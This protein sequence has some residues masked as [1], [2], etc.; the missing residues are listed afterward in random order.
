[1]SGIAE[2]LLN[3]GY[4]VT[5]SDL[6]KTEVTDHL[7]KLGA[8]IFI[9]HKSGNIGK[10]NVV[11]T[12]TAVGRSNPEVV[13]AE[14]NKI[15]VIPRIEMLA[16]LARLKYAVTIAGTHGKTTTT[17]MAALVLEK[18]NLDPTVVIGGR[19]KNI[20][21][22]AKL[23]HGEFLVAE[24]DES[25]G[26]F[27]KLSPAIAVVTNIDN[28]HLDYY[29]TLENI[30]TAFVKHINSVPFYG[31]AVLCLD[32]KNVLEILP[33]IKRRYQT[34]SLDGR[35]DF[36]ARNIKAL[37]SGSSFNVLYKNK[38]L[39]NITLHV[40]GMHN[41]LNSLAAIAVGVELSIPFPKIRKAISDFAGVGR[42]LEIKGNKKG[43]MIIDDY[44]HHPT[45]VRAT[46]AAIKN[47]WPDRRLVV[48]FQPHRYSRTQYLHK[49][50]GSAFSDADSIR[51]L[52]IYPA[53][54]T[55]IPGVT[56]G[57]IYD[58][59]KS[60]G[61]EVEL[62]TNEKSVL[63]ELRSGDILLTLGAGDVWKAGEEL[64]RLI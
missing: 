2:V 33:Q 9:G 41:I 19:L 40:P 38:K 37:D 49:E 54:E 61:K 26:S 50:F 7:R 56:S 36:T 5:G 46:L 3:L 52:E 8:R 22:G 35:G 62:F 1:M 17:S 45:E 10:A 12:S 63:S 6:K 55:P 58:A 27:L 60:T 20:R 31:C 21:S 15:P 34:Y 13:E 11:V 57:L 43:I 4:K 53:G 59:V 64:L 24:A 25:D 39:G 32:D 28:D 44:G 48:L 23:G 16:E 14:R 42:R 30:K 51:L 47:N 18:G 29:G